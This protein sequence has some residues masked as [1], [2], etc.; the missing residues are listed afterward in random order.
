M[1]EW[2]D[3]F[4]VVQWLAWQFSSARLSPHC[5]LLEA[6]K[7]KKKKKKTLVDGWVGALQSILN[8]A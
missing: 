6:Q 2:M 1:Q 5:P 3:H 8:E 7:F 4:N